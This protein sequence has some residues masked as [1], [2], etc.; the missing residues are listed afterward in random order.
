M[1]KEKKKKSIFKK[2]WFW[3]V[4]SIAII[5]LL[6]GIILFFI[7]KIPSKYYG[8]YTRYFYFDG[9]EFKTTYKIS[10]LKIKSI[11]E[12]TIDA[13][14]KIE[15]KDIEY[16]KKGKDLIIKENEYESYLIID[17]DCLYVETNKDI[18]T[19]KEYGLFYWNVKSDEA[20]LYK[21]ENKS[22]GM[23]DLIE[24]TMNTWARELIY[25]TI[26][27][28]MENSDFYIIKSDKESDKT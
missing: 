9:N 14:S 17:D 7:N 24:K 10:P 27:Q 3:T 19:S 15:E 20:D 1:E 13:E 12:S 8:T 23:E 28:K 16:S 25:D 6:I 2:W 22:E 11:L 4:I 26:N 5:I 18:S 21:I